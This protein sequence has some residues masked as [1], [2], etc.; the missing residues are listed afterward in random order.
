MNGYS[1]GFI[2]FRDES[3][4]MEHVKEI[5]GKNLRI[6]IFKRVTIKNNL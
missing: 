1:F 3:E 2:C 5:E 4:I 6:T